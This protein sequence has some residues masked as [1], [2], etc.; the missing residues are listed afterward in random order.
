MIAAYVA[1]YAVALFLMVVGCVVPAI[2]VA[3]AAHSVH[4]LPSLVRIQSIRDIDG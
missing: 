2:L 3:L 4:R 1:L